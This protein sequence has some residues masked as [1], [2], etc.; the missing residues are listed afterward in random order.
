M[1]EACQGVMPPGWIRPFLLVSIEITHDELSLCD[2]TYKLISLVE[3]VRSALGSTALVF[4]YCRQQSIQPTARGFKALI[5][6]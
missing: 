2:N 3:R 6:C 4:S 5:C 1:K